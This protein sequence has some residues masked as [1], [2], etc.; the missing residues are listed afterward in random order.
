MVGSWSG[1]EL[2]V[3]IKET[4]EGVLTGGGVSKCGLKEDSRL[5]VD[6]GS[7]GV[8]H[9]MM[10]LPAA[11]ETGGNSSPEGEGT[12]SINQSIISQRSINE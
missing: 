2:V 7:R 1:A 4:V 6:S 3:V 11:E 8:S 10:S 5:E 12:K 9:C